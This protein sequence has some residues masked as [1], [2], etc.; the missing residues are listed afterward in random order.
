MNRKDKSLEIVRGVALN[1]TAD[2]LML[3]INGRFVE[4][5][6]TQVALLAMLHD[7]AGRVVPYKRLYSTMGHRSAGLRQRHILRQHMVGIKKALDK[8]KAPL[9]LSVS[10]GVGYALCEVASATKSG[11]RPRSK[12]ATRG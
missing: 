9:A 11:H 6:Q 2:R 8:F 10:T 7:E 5:N 3:F 12:G 1:G 4:A